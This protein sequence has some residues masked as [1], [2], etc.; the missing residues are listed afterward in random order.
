MG[1]SGPLVHLHPRKTAM[2][3]S[4]SIPLHIAAWAAVFALAA[5]GDDVENPVES[6][7]NEVI[8]T[9]TLSFVPEGGGDAVQAQ[10]R[11][12]DGQGGEDPAVTGVTLAVGVTY[13]MTPE[14][15]NELETPAE[16]ITIEIFDE[17]NEHQTFMVGDVV[18]GPATNVTTGALVRHAYDDQDDFGIPVGLEN[19]VEALAIGDGTFSFGLRHMPLVNNQPQKG[20]G[21]ADLVA[22]G[23]GFSSEDAA[24]SLPGSWDAVVDFP[25]TVE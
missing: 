25:L 5:C 15:L 17:R 8:T 22:A 12:P 7:P 16:D 13:T 18:E 2:Q 19:T 21:L 4:P 6:N 10:F 11:D 20:P 3:R 1:W 23:G 9:V 24:T 14:F